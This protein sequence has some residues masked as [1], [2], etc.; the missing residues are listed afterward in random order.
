MAI[1]QLLPVSCEPRIGT[2][3]TRDRIPTQIN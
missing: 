3:R 1:I 2:R